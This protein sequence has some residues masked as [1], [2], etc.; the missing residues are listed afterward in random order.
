MNYRIIELY[1]LKHWRAD[2]LRQCTQRFVAQCLGRASLHPFDFLV[3]K[4]AMIRS[5]CK[6]LDLKV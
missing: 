6:G 5:L 2:A 1:A 4:N 3:S